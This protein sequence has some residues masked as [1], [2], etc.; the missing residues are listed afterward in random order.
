MNK[1][2]FILQLKREL[3]PLKQSARQEILADFEEH[4][5]NGQAQGKTEDQVAQELGS[6]KEL[7]QE[8][9]ESAEGNEK[10][11]NAGGIGRGILTAFGL[12]LFDAM[13]LIPI[14]AAFFAIVVS[15]WA[16]PL[17]LFASSIALV[18]YPLINIAFAIPYIVSLLVA[19]A[20][21][22][23][24]VAMGIGMFYMS[25]YFIKFVAEIGKAQ[26]RII[27]GGSRG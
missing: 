4:F 17:S 7:A 20:L 13:I 22:A 2:T 11:I 12:L 23:L 16:V 14:T 25:K 26:Y 9:I 27:V 18:V 21:L 19:I 24:S 6:P 10:S 8:Y 1:Q 15:L 3:E 5:A